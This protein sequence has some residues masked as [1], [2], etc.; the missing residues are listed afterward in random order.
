MQDVL[1]QESVLPIPPPSQEE[2]FIKQ[3]DHSHRTTSPLINPP[4]SLRLILNTAIEM[5]MRNK[6]ILRH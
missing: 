3:Q 6:L 4:E 5:P 1:K 2:G